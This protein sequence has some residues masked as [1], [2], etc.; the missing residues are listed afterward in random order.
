MNAK[1]VNY[2]PEMTAEIVADYAAGNT[3]EAIA[4]KTGKTV[5]SIVAKLSREGVYHAKARVAK[6][7]GVTKADLIARIAELTGQA[8]EVMDSLEKATGVALKA[9][10]AALEAK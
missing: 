10:V 2:T 5:R 4:A 8:P 7:D 3:L 1:T 6:K 9:V